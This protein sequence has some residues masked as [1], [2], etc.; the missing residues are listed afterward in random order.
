MEKRSEARFRYSE[1]LDAGLGDM[2]LLL[3]RMLA[4]ECFVLYDGESESRLVVVER[5]SRLTYT[6]RPA[7][8]TRQANAGCDRNTVSKPC[9]V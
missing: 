1:H 7:P 9:L 3:G 8:P 2:V 5:T 4:Y 6:A